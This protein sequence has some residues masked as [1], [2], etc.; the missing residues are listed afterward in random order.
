MSKITVPLQ[1]IEIE[2]GK[3]VIAI[4]VPAHEV[5]VLRAIHKPDAI[6]VTDK[7]VGVVERDNNANSEFASLQR[8]YVR[9]GS[10]DPVRLA[11]PEGAVG[12]EKHGFVFDADAREERAPQSRV[13]NHAKKPAKAVK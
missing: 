2:R 13:R 7:D 8:K 10:P 11:Y 4:E 1:A 12:L 6:R 3:D 5:N 9:I